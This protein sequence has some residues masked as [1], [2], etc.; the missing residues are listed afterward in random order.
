MVVASKAGAPEHPKWF[1]NVKANPRVTV[2]VAAGETTETFDAIARIVSNEAERKTLYEFMTV[3]WPQFADY[4]ARTSRTIQVG[5]PVGD[6]LTD[7]VPHLFDYQPT[8]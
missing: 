7:H 8:K 4:A 5:H 3:V 2:E 1:S 6:E